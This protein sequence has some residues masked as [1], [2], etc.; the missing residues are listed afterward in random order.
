M[1][2]SF[3]QG[4]ILVI[5]LG[6]IIGCGLLI[7]YTSRGQRKEETDETTGHNYDGIEELDNPLPRWWV[8]MFWS[9]IVFAVAYMGV[10]GFGNIKGFLTVEVDGEQVAWSS[11]NQWKEEVQSFEQKIAP[12]Y[13]EYAETPI[14]ELIHNE[15]AMQTG[16]RLFKSN[17]S[18]CHGTTAKGARGFPNLT[19]DDWLYGGEPENIVQTITHGRIAAMPAWQSVLGDEGVADMTQYVRSLSG[20]EHDAAAAERAAP[21]FQQNCMVCH[22]A[23]GKGNQLLGAP[24]LTDEIWLYGGSTKDIAF[25]LKNGR[26]G[27]MPNFS[28]IWDTNTK[29]KIHV[30]SAY[31]YS[32]SQD[33]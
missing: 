29:Q 2:D 18:V 30:V 6:S 20:L 7:Q 21:K 8:M 27:R 31:V 12:L 24:N 28:E 26:N 15:E 3:W 19:D 4:W 13:N 1:L 9:T 10:Y 17:C 33:K 25:T 14:A 16:Q 23:N 32:L 5:T 11:H 22:G